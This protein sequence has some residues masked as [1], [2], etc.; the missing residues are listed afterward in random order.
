[1]NDNVKITTFNNNNNSPLSPKPEKIDAPIENSIR[2]Q[3]FDEFVGQSRIKENLGVFVKAAI[4]RKEAIDHIL[5]CGP[6]GLGK[7]TLSHIIAHEMKA[8][9]HITSGPAMEKKGDLAGILTNIAKNDV[10]FI[11][12]IHRLGTVVEENLYPAMEDFSFDLIIGEGPAARTFKMPLEKFTLVGATTRQGLLTTPLR[13]RFGITF[14]LDYYSAEEL[15]WVIKRTS[16]IMNLKF[17]EAGLHEIAMRSRGTPRIANRLL[18]RTSDY[19]LIKGNGEITKD[20]ARYALSKL[21]VDK[22]G[23]DLVDRRIMMSM[24]E[25]YNGGPVGIDT[26]AVTIGEETD[27]IEDV[28]EPFLIQSGFIKR[29][30]RGRIVTEHGYNHLNMKQE[31]KKEKSSQDKLF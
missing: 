3:K 24:I 12:E 25:K 26:I 14:H 28:H 2:P 1:M 21:E 20:I 22:K 27:T 23:L 11:D 29:T 8:N 19:A 15:F 18:R 6:P 5:F 7:T 13:D 30:P 17:E 31:I 9:I 4:M 16:A 10:L